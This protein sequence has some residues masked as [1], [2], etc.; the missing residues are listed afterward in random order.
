MNF[1]QELKKELKAQKITQEEISAELCKHDANL[2][3]SIKDEKVRLCDLLKI[4]KILKLQLNL[5]KIK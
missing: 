5:S 3:R 1:Y 2:W 4:C